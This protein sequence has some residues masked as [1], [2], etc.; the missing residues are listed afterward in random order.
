VPPFNCLVG[1]TQG[2][3]RVERCVVIGGAHA[4]F[5][6]AWNDDL[7][8]K[9]G[10]RWRTF[11]SAED[12][13]P[14][15][16]L[17]WRQRCPNITHSSACGSETRFIA[18]ASSGPLGRETG[19]PDELRDNG[20]V[21][22]TPFGTSHVTARSKRARRNVALHFCPQRQVLSR[23]WD[24]LSAGCA[25]SMEASA[26]LSFGTTGTGPWPRWKRLPPS[27]SL[28]WWVLALSC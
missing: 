16:P 26:W 4:S 25:L 6:Q 15:A 9:P 12:K 3:A 20:A 21:A 5:S 19:R 27:S 8:A 22:P 14:R 2:T 10:A 17:Y 18:I 23:H 7:K 13:R 1:S 28:S 24:F 11:C